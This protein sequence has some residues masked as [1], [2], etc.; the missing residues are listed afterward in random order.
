VRFYFREQNPNELPTPTPSREQYNNVSVE[1][2]MFEDD[3]R[4][5][6]VP[7]YEAKRNPYLIGL[8][9]VLFLHLLTLSVFFSAFMF[10]AGIQ[11]EWERKQ[12]FMFLFVVGMWCGTGRAQR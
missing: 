11:Y 4:D 1:A 3:A 5:I 12:V 7:A 2:V 8:V 9:P 10:F 6:P